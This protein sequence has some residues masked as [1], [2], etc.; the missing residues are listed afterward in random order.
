MSIK[1]EI[2]E[3]LITTKLQEI[4]VDSGHGL[5]CLDASTFLCASQQ[6]QNLGF[7]QRKMYINITC[8]KLL[9]RKTENEPSQKNKRANKTEK[10]KIN[11]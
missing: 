5:L 10:M 9:R 2:F 7:D 11:I 1:H 3:D 8:S 6:P 4:N